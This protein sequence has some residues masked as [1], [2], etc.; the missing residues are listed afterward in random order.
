MEK[1]KPVRDGHFTNRTLLLDFPSDFAIILI[2]I[3]V[4]LCVQKLDPCWKCV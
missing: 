1:V 3:K 4:L 2:L